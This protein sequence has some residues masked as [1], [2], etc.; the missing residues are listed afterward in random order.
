[1]L[2]LMVYCKG[3]MST[4]E[5]LRDLFIRYASCSGQI[6]NTR[7]SSIHA[8]GI[9]HGRLNSM[10]QLLGF[11]IGTLPFTYLGAPIF[12][13][14]PKRIHFQCIAD[15]IKNKLAYWK[16]CLL[17]I[18]GRAQLI[19]YVVQGM[20]IH[21]MSVFSWPT[22]LL[23]DIEK[24][25]KN[26][27]WSGDTDKRKLVTI[28]WKKVCGNYDEGGLGIRS[29]VN[30]N[31]ATNL[32]MC[33]DLMQ[34]DE[35]WAILLRRRVLRNSTC[36]KHHIFSSI[37]SGVIQ[38]LHLQ[39]SQIHRFPSKLCHYSHNFH[40]KI[41]EEV[42]QIVPNLS[43]LIY[44]VTIPSHNHP[45]R[46]I[47][48]HNSTGDL[49]LKEAY[50]FKKH[51]YPTLQWAKIIWS[52]DFPPS[53]SLLVW[54]LMLNKLPT[55]DNLSARGCLLPSM[56][57]LCGNQEETS[58]H[59]FFE[60]MYAVNLWCWFASMINRTLQFQSMEDMWSICNASWNPQCKIIITATMIN[61]INSIWFAGNQMRFQNKII[62]RKSSLATVK[63]NTALCGNISK[64]VAS[65]N[66]SNFVIL[67]KFDV[68]LHPPRAPQ[69]I[70]V[71]W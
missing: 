27:L 33:W 52:K 17:S 4:L 16:A 3:K 49:T 48:K 13:G 42:N 22:S 23:R 24:W 1:V 62:H 68:T 51:R 54:R 14:K 69:I 53:K 28:S 70:E 29:L 8:G 26:F 32:K 20:L 6:I 10:V 65:N 50:N 41:S 18:A 21:T 66:I 67:K 61:I 36:I 55:D 38:S 15:K 58:F 59:L 63:S 2:R 43:F 30:L 5:A 46:L 34:S 7:K 56:C 39:P 47:W 25:I 12:K 19:K 45:D 71:I 37:W 11:S 9:S 31:Q 44:H 60:C 57:S 35:D 64:V 40:W